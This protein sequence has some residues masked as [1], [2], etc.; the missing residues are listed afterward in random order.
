MNDALNSA[1]VDHIVDICKHGLRS[2]TG[3][4]GS[5]Y[6][7]RI[8]KHAL[9]GGFIFETILYSNSVSDV[10]SVVAEWLLDETVPARTNRK[11]VM[12]DRYA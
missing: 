10:E 2:H 12:S 5:N 4:N 11:N 9:I 3:S 1:A 8:E 6:Q 7:Q